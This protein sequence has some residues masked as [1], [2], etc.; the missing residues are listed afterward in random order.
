MADFALWATACETALWPAGTFSQAYAANRSAAIEGIMDADSIA[1]C[2]REL[3]T[4]RNSWT[5]TAADLL[6]ISVEHGSQTGNGAA[7]VKNARALAGHLRRVQ[8][9][10][11]AVGVDI[12]FSREGRAGTRIIRI[13]RSVENSVSTVISVKGTHDCGFESASGEHCLPPSGGQIPEALRTAADGA[14]ATQ[15]GLTEASLAS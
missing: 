3:I 15:T 14:D 4:E 2:V 5:G 13:R 9:F 7:R 1:A 6:R 8:T 10:L 11:R 12:G